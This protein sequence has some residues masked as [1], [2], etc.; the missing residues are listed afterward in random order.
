MRC[1]RERT[2]KIYYQ[3]YLSTT[4]PVFSALDTQLIRPK[5]KNSFSKLTVRLKEL[6]FSARMNRASPSSLFTPSY[7]KSISLFVLKRRGKRVRSQKKGSIDMGNK[8]RTLFM[9]SI[10]QPLHFLV[11]T[12]AQPSISSSPSQLPLP[13]PPPPVENLK[14]LRMLGQ[15]FAY[16]TCTHLRKYGEVKCAYICCLWRMQ[17]VKKKRGNYF[18][19]LPQNERREEKSEIRGMHS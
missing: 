7:P 15:W 19:K 12:T 14:N 17:N 3:K 2:I 5:K 10:C 8:R 18:L 9:S 4:V 1:D 11:S 16:K 13:K 6:H